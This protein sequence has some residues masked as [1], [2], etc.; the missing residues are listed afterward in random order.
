MSTYQQS[1]V[2]IYCTCPVIITEI[3]STTS[4]S[5]LTE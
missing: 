3:S 4:S 5:F 2:R 1:S